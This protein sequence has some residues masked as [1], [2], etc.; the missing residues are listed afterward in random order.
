MRYYEEKK[1]DQKQ[2]DQDAV[3]QKFEEKKFC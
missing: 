1:N 3:F 2:D